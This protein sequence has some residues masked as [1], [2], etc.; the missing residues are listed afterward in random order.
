MVV[1]MHDILTFKQL[2]NHR[3]P[4]VFQGA[5]ENVL[6]SNKVGIRAVVASD[7]QKVLSPSVF[8]CHRSTAW[9]FLGGISGINS[10]KTNTVLFCQLF[11]PCYH[12]PICPRGYCFTKSLPP[13]GSLAQFEV[14][15]VLDSQNTKRIPREL[16]GNPVDVITTCSRSPES[17]IATRLTTTD[18]STNG[19]G[20]LAVLLAFGIYKQLVEAYIHGQDLAMLLLLLWNFNP[21]S[22]PTISECTALK[23]FGA[24]FVE[25]IIEALMAFERDNNR[26]AFD[27]PRDFQYIIKCTFTR[28]DFG[29]QATQAYR[30]TNHRAC[31]WS[32]GY[33]CNLFGGNNSLQRDLK[34]IAPVTIRKASARYTVESFSVEPARVNPKKIDIALGAGKNFTAQSGETALFRFRGKF[35]RDFD[36]TFHLHNLPRFIVDIKD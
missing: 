34:A 10:N 19:L 36:R 2:G 6:C 3:Q 23:D 20:L 32:V 4:R 18:P 26:F 8:L 14:F 27:K 15:Q 29:N 28:F 35:E 30:T 11:D 25:P 12:L 31:C 5:N 17:A 9:T 13:V 33:A 16:L 21:K 1:K 22:S 7:T 24:L